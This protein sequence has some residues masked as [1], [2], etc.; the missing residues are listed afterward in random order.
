MKLIW[1]LILPLVAN[2]MSICAAFP[3]SKLLY[4]GFFNG[5]DF[6]LWKRAKI[7]STKDDPCLDEFQVSHKPQ[8]GPWNPDDCHKAQCIGKGIILKRMCKTTNPC[9]PGQYLKLSSAP[10]CVCMPVPG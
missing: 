4:K 1:L 10:C 7:S 5:Q 3:K 9:P 6:E 8:M 2:M